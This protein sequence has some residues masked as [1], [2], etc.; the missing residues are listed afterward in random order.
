M[1]TATLTL[2]PSLRSFGLAILNWIE[3]VTQTAYDASSIARDL[4]AAHALSDEAL[5]ERGVTRDQVTRDIAIR[6]GYI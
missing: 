4:K 1:T 3:H 5:A 2:V 6:Y